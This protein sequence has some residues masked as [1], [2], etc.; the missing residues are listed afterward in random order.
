MKLIEKSSKVLYLAE[1]IIEQLLIISKTK[2][3]D[4]FRC[5]LHDDEKS[6][7]MSMLIVIRNKYIY[8]AHRHKWK[9]ETYTILRGSC[10]YEEYEE[11]GLIKN[12]FILKEGDHLL[13]NHKSYHRLKPLTENLVFIENTV[14]P[15]RKN[16][17]EFL[18]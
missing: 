16:S 14:G 6:S 11:K 9:D 15:F 2:C 17:L 3:Q 5:C 12:H 4:L 13:N 8:P 7:L 10:I 1:D 18:D